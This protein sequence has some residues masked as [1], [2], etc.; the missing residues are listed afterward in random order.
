MKKKVAW[1]LIVECAS[2]F[3]M[4]DMDFGKISLIKHS[5]RLMENTPFKEHCWH[6]PPNLYDRYENTLKRYLQLVLYNHL[7]AIWLVQSY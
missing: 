4:R 7:I 2:T 6:I 5:V 3:Y 1:E